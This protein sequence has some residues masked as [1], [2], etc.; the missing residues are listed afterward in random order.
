MGHGAPCLA[1]ESCTW[2]FVQAPLR[3]PS[4]ATVDGAGLPTWT[5]AGLKS[6]SAPARGGVVGT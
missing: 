6:Q 2:I 5:S 1:R 4:Y 3:V